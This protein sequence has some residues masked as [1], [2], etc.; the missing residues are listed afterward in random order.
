MIESGGSQCVIR[1]RWR[2]CIDDINGQPSDLLHRF[3]TAEAP[4][5]NAGIV[6]PYRQYDFKSSTK[7]WDQSISAD[8]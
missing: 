5:D 3:D 8:S 4:T 1:K 6:S 7:E 2:C